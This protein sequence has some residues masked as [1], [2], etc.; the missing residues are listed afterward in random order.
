MCSS[1]LEVGGVSY[2]VA[3]TAKGA[4]MIMPNMATMLS[5]VLS[6]ASL[7]PA[8]IDSIFR[9]SVDRSF[10]AI[11]VDGDTSTNDT[12]L[13][14][15]NGAAGTAVILPAPQQPSSLPGCWTKCCWIWPGRL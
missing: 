9:R 3:G 5:F 12:C 11:T 1:D 6:D 8:L 10:N 13:L 4:G 15:A 14:M 7:D 2:T